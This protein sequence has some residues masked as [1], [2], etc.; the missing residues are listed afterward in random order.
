MEGKEN[1]YEEYVEVLFEYKRLRKILF[2][3]LSKACECVQEELWYISLTNAVMILS[4]LPKSTDC[5][6]LQR[7]F[8]EWRAYV[9]VES[10][11][12]VIQRD[13]LPVVHNPA[14]ESNETLRLV[15][16][17]SQCIVYYYLFRRS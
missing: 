12:Q 9:D 7:W 13:K 16:Y 2:L 5:Y 3:R 1:E 11:D 8:E 4:V 14:F 10:M 17:T 6:F 15:T